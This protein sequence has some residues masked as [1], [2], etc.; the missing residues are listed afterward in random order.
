[1]WAFESLGFDQYS[2]L[3]KIYLQRY[4][5]LTK[6]DKGSGAYDDG[7]MGAGYDLDPQAF[8]GTL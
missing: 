8:A 2:H 1:M 4:K 6:M 7:Q 3:M 5:E